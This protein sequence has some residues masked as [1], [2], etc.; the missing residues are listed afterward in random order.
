MATIGEQINGALRLI[1]QLAEGEVPSA[2]TANDALTAFNQMLDS[3]STERLAVFSTIDQVFTWPAGSSVQALG[4]TGTFVGIRPITLLDSTYFTDLGTSITYPVS[5]VTEADY[6]SIT[7]KSSSGPYPQIIYPKPTVPDMQLTVYPVP[8][9]ALEWHFS[10]VAP[11]SQ[12]TELAA[13]LI[14]PPGYLR[15]FRYNLACEIAT[16]FGTEPPP[17]VARIA[18]V[19]KRDIKRINNPSDVLQMPDMLPVGKTN[20]NIYTGSV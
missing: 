9:Q 16:E 18:M 7:L 11:L 17:N 4:P 1:G 15:A 20:F 3:W 6:N 14:V 2:D 13:E 10:S 19:S 5:V 8:T 12:A